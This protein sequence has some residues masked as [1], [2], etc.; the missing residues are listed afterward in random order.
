MR[1]K[2][3][4]EARRQG[5]VMECEKG[6]GD[7]GWRII[8]G[9]RGLFTKKR[10]KLSLKVLSHWKGKAADQL[11]FSFCLFLTHK[12]HTKTH[13]MSPPH[14]KTVTHTRTKLK[15]KEDEAYCYCRASPPV[16]TVLSSSR[17]VTTNQITVHVE[18]RTKKKHPLIKNYSNR[19]GAWW[20]DDVCLM[21]RRKR[22]LH[23]CKFQYSLIKMHAED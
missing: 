19:L 20:L 9:M 5:E 10:K 8:N 2:W 4:L 14:C 7:K 16:S 17:F 1:H 18:K 22:A 13:S 3:L 21:W 6:R 15:R 11:S 23:C 12:L